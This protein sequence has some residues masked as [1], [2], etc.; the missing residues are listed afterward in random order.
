V[1]YLEFW[2]VAKV[3]RRRQWMR[4]G[5]SASRC[6]WGLGKFFNFLNENG[7]FWCTLEHSFKVNV[8]ATEGLA[9]YVHAL[10]V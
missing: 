7:V 2:K 6:D 9:P 4:E 10:C 3:E 8:P 1:A 5:V